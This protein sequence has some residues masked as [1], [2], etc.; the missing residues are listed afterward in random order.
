LSNVHSHDVI[1]DL[2]VVIPTLGRPILEESLQAIE[3]GSK[4]PACIVVVDQG[5]R[6][7][8]ARWLAELSERR[9]G[10]IALRLLAHQLRAMR[11][12][13]RG[14]LKR[15]AKLTMIGRAYATGLLPGVWGGL[16]SRAPAA[17]RLTQRQ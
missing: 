15:D 13:L 7:E 8:V 12:W 17:P 2:T 4:W 10:F 5:Q 11:R 9:D 1:E 3:A 14:T 16:R 6:S